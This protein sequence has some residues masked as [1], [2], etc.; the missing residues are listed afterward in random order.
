MDHNAFSGT[1]PYAFS[2]LASLDILYL[3]NNNL[4]GQPWGLST[5]PS[6]SYLYLANSGLCGY[7]PMNHMPDDASL[8]SCP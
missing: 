5:L 1:L 6:L 7:V 8:P 3:S 4:S 2:S